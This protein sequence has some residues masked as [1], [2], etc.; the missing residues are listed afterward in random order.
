MKK[1]SN[2]RKRKKREMKR[3]KEMTIFVD[4]P[5]S[6]ER[7]GRES[8]DECHRSRSHSLKRQVQVG[9]HLERIQM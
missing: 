7:G 9:A 3:D 8:L 6:I 2:E 5:D 1:V 4:T